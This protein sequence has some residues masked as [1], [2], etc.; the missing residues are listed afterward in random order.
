M[1]ETRSEQVADPV[2]GV[3]QQFD[4]LPGLDVLGQD[5]DAGAGMLGTD[6]LRRHQPFAGV[7]R[8]HPDVGHHQI[9]RFPLHR[10]M[11]PVRIARLPGHDKSVLGQDPGQPFAEQHRVVGQHHPDRRRGRGTSG[12]RRATRFR[13][14]G[15]LPMLAP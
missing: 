1:S 8:R 2:R 11:Q 15:L 13:H 4:R 14:D 10:R 12:G 9:G 6:P 3:L 7:R 5:Q